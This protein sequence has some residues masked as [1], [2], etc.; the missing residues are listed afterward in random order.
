MVDMKL[1]TYKRL[2]DK[3]HL[4]EIAAQVGSSYEYIWEQLPGGH[5]K[6]SPELAKKIEKATSGKV[7]RSDLRPDIYS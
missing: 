1:K 6:A 5:S 7:S 3:P 2:H 4:L